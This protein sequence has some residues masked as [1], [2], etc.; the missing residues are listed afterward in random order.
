MSTTRMV[1]KFVIW[2]AKCWLFH[3]YFLTHT[4]IG[5]SKI[6]LLQLVDR[7][8]MWTMA[9]GSFRLLLYVPIGHPISKVSQ[10]DRQS[11][12]YWPPPSSLN[13][14]APSILTSICVLWIDCTCCLSLMICWHKLL[15]R[16]LSNRLIYV[17]S[18]QLLLTFPPLSSS[19]LVTISIVLVVVC[20]S[21]S[22]TT[23]I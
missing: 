18:R 5:R 7:V 11:A 20:G 22:S 16:R 10:R 21:R 6:N 2:D 12:A 23:I 13:Y 14:S 3:I 4:S 8:C 9:A 17:T 1:H 19:H 15:K